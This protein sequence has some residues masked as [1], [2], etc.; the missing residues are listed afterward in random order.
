M[1]QYLYPDWILIFGRMLK[2]EVREGQGTRS[3]LLGGINGH[4]DFVIA[5]SLDAGFA[6]FSADAVIVRG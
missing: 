2:R 5:D 1:T 4:P 6:K 3:G